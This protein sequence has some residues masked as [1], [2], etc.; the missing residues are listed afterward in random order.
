VSHI[1]R[2]IAGGEVLS[3]A[4]HLT[5]IQPPGKNIQSTF[6]FSTRMLTHKL[7]SLLTFL[8]HQRTI[9]SDLKHIYF[10]HLFRGSSNLS[11]ARG[12]E[13]RQT[14]TEA[15]Q[16]LW[17]QLRNRKLKGKKFR[18]QHPLSGF[19]LD[20]YCHECKLAIEVDGN[21]HANEEAKEYDAARTH[22]LNLYGI[23]LLRFWNSEV[24]ND[25]EGV[26]E[27]ISNYLD[28]PTGH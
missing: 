17:Q 26:L 16:K 3:D 23:T 21:C 25:I 10:K 9:L 18:R 20:F 8:L 11:F 4:G 13:L 28:R 12:R 2:E 19:I 5:T 14:S 7:S 6:F 24:I 1:F 27:K 15:E 22:L